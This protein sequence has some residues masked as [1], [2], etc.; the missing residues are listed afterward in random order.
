MFMTALHLSL[1]WAR[2]IQSMPPHPTSWR[3]ILIS[4]HLSLGLPSGLFPLRFPHQN[5]IC[6]YPFLHSATYP[7]HFILLEWIRY[8]TQSAD[9]FHVKDVRV[10]SLRSNPRSIYVIYVMVKSLCTLKMDVGWS[11]SRGEPTA[12]RVQISVESD[13]PSRPT[14]MW[15]EVTYAT[16]SVSYAGL[17]AQCSVLPAQMNRYF[18]Q[19][20]YIPLQFPTLYGWYVIELYAWCTWTRAAGDICAD[21]TACVHVFKYLCGEEGTRLR[22]ARSRGT[23]VVWSQI[24]LLCK[25]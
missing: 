22:D 1:S 19:T 12:I 16:Y 18:P 24:V 2:S 11:G 6:T 13:P 17:P 3:S 4:S 9:I 23:L 25:L 21:T 20:L 7:A 10:G 15:Q 14:G 8:D 5:P